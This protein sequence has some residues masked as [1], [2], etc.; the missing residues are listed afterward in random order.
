MTQATLFPLPE[1]PA[2]TIKQVEEAFSKGPVVTQAIAGDMLGI[3]RQSVAYLVRTGKLESVKVLQ[4]TMVVVRSVQERI[5]D[6]CR[7]NSVHS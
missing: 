7:E 5:Q 4:R 1:L 3:R 2:D 6:A